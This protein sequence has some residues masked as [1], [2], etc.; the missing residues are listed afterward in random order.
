M[1]LR[2]RRVSYRSC[3]GLQGGTPPDFRLEVAIRCVV[4]IDGEHYPPVIDS[5]IG[6]LARADRKVVGAVLVGG[7]EKLPPEGLTR[8]ADVDVR[9]GDDAPTVLDETIAELRPELVV[10]LSDEPVL[11]YRKRHQLAAVALMRGVPYEG[12]DFLFTPPPRPRL[13][14]KPSL[15]IIG[16]GKRTG[17]T[18]IAGFVARCLK[19]ET[20]EP[21]VVAMGRGGPAEPEVLRGDRVELTPKDLL[22]LA[23]EGK[24]AAS[25]YIEDA[26][27]ARVP[28]VGCRRC[29][30]GLAGGVQISNVQA[31]V[32]IANELEGDLIIL[33]GSGAAIPPAHADANL[34]VVGASIPEEYLSGYMGYY[35]LLLADAVVI[36]MCEEPFGS[37]SHISRITSLIRDASR[38]VGDRRKKEGDIRL[39]QTVFRPHPVS[40]VDG[41]DAFVATTAPE[42]A[43]ERIKQHLEERYHCRVRGISHSLAD[44][45]QLERDLENLEAEVL[46]CEIKA[47]GIEVATRRALDQ[48]LEVVYMDNL[49][50]AVDGQ[51]LSALVVALAETARSRFAA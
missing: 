33:E 36:T 23:D 12:A 15:A 44:R 37:P 35:R 27:L 18:A 32:A 25:D 40:A 2:R 28:T 41:A 31:G 9:S 5:A 47:A 34:L 45:K 30:G 20:Y 26:L 17:K 1:V 7:K 19:D 16:T 14:E 22:A 46:L 49:P 39:M 13:C 42:A 3:P 51:D 6:W 43:G 10:D 4:V 11:D 24:H 21:V 8:L 29:A 48:G 50:Q 38:S